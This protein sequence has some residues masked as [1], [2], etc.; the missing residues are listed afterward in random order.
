MKTLAFAFCF[1]ATVWGQRGG[2]P[3]PEAARKAQQLLREGKYAE[4]ETA[5][6]AAV[7][8]APDSPQ[9]LNAAGTAFDL[10]GKSKEAQTYF[11]K[12]IDLAKDPGAKA[13]AQRAMAM[14][15]AFEGDCKNAAKYE[16]LVFD[17]YVSMED[18]YQQGEI[19]DEAARVCIDSGDLDAAAKYYKM[20]YDAGLK[21]SEIPPDRVKLWNFRYEHALARIAARHGNKAEAAKHVALAKAQ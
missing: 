10:A 7:A 6:R 5:F 21:Q 20:G 19:A 14:S 17:H 2:P 8:A 12:A 15:F 3:L 9:V 11:Q 1:A 4:A 13:A 18:A 16:M